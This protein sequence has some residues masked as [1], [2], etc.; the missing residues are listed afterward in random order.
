M[1][2]G[3]RGSGASAPA[4]AGAGSGLQAS[5]TAAGGAVA[6]ATCDGAASENWTVGANSHVVASGGRC[7][8]VATGGTASVLRTCNNASADQRWTLLSNGQ[9]RGT[10]LTCLTFTGSSVSTMACGSDTSQPLYS[11]PASQRWAR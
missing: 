7:L 9:L 4:E 11:P 8:A 5:R 1:A 6:V 10:A 3:R 2:A